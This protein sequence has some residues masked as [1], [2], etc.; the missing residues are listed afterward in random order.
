MLT[1]RKEVRQKAKTATKDE[2]EEMIY[3]A[4]LT[5]MQEEIIRLHIVKDWT[6]CKIAL[7]VHCSESNI[8]KILAA[9]YD[10]MS[11]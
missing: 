11:K 8:R 6:I 7:S 5:P 2:F 4:N 10:K 9:T 1:T 3:K